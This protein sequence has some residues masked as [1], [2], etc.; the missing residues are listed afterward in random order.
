MEPGDSIMEVLDLRAKLVGVGLAEDRPIGVASIRAC[1][2]TISPTI[3]RRRGVSRRNPFSPSGNFA[4]IVPIRVKSVA[5]PASRA[6]TRT[7]A[8][9]AA[10]RWFG[11]W[12]M[13]RS[14]SVWPASGS[15]SV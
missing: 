14:I 1:T 15:F 2:R 6:S 11:Y 13:S 3:S 5:R 4:T 7:R 8:R 10:V 9:K 12:A